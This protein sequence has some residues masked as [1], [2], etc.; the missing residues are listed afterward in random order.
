[1]AI[2]QLQ[3]IEEAQAAVRACYHEKT[4][5]YHCLVSG[6]W[7]GGVLDTEYGER[8]W[9]SIGLGNV[10]VSVDNLPKTSHHGVT[11][12]RIRVV[13]IIRDREGKT[14]KVEELKYP[15]EYDIRQAVMRMQRY[16]MECLP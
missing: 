3:T 12:N 9:N 1:M 13:L 11:R 6:G 10:T 7:H 5:F 14:H 2:K 8:I 4:W 16:E 15:T